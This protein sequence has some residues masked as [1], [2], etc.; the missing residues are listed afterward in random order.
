MP[1]PIIASDLQRCHYGD[2]EC[3]RKTITSYAITLANGRRDLGLVPFD[4]LYVDKVDIQ[5]GSASP[6]NV[7]LKFRNL[8]CFGMSTAKIN[9]VVG[10]ERDPSKSKFEFIAHIDHISLVGQYKVRGNILLLPIIGNGAVNL[11]F[12]KLLLPS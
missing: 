3:I 4:P 8:K 2:V 5:Q 9:N 6:V 1:F 10:F 7:N 11:T 12:G